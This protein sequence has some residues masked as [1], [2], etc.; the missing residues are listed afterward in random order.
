MPSTAAQ[1]AFRV[2]L[3]FVPDSESS[4][5]NIWLQSFCLRFKCQNMNFL[6]KS[7]PL[8]THWHRHGHK[9]HFIKLGNSS[10]WASVNVNTQIKAKFEKLNET[11]F[12]RCVHSLTTL[13]AI[14]LVWSFFDSRRETDLSCS[15]AC[16]D[17]MF[18]LHSLQD[19]DRRE[20]VE[21]RWLTTCLATLYVECRECGS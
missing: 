4:S 5:L 16:A 13:F 17:A 2:S 15:Q 8:P 14:W 21:N 1:I 12:L 7:A 6:S 10:S 18:W 9:N 11:H 20:R 19:A 3:R